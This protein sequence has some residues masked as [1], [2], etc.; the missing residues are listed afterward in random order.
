MKSK[1]FYVLG[2]VGFIAFI[3]GG[4]LLQRGSDEAGSI[5]QQARLFE[6]V[7]AYIADYYVDPIDEREIYDMAID[8]LL[9]ELDDPYTVFLRPA[10]F[11]RLSISTT[12]N[13]GG[14]GIRIEVSDGWI[15][16]VTPL[17]DT[18]AERAGVQAGDRIVE[19]E[20]ESTR[21]WPIDRA[22]SV[23]RGP[24]GE[25]AN[26]TIVRPGVPEPI[27]FSIKRERIHVRAV[28]FGTVFPGGIGYVQFATIS[29]SSARE[30]GEEVAR[31]QQE[32]ATSLILDLRNNPGGLL[33]EGVAVSDLFLDRGDV[34][35]ETRGRAPGASEVFRASR[36]QQWTDMPLIALVNGASASAAEIIAGALQDHDRALIL[37]TPS[38]GKGLVQ[39]VY[40]LGPGRRALKITTGR[41][42]TPTGRV[43]ER[44]QPPRPTLVAGAAADDE[45]PIASALV[46]PDSAPRFYTDAGRVVY[47]GG[48]I[49]PDRTVELTS[50]S[51]GEEEFARQLGRR[52]PDYRSVLT[53]YA[54]DIKGEGNITAL[55]FAV[56]PAMRAELVRR[57][58]E[59][60]IDLED[61]VWRGASELL[62]RVL[63][64][65]IARYVFGRQAEVQRQLTRDA[66][67]QEALSLLR[68]AGSPSELFQLAS[69][70]QEDSSR[71]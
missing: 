59:R 17:P 42:Y 12:G 67:V 60:G 20:G 6:N 51:D 53:S 63:G 22:V 24:A 62:N 4:W 54:L 23:L 50:L 35:V 61:D 39:T 71:N 65:E 41:W 1:N 52:I 18:P 64:Y 11:E 48:G 8:G 66:Q 57:L 31:L 16:V 30:L 33:N 46:P 3:S 32:G 44:P 34:V 2:L 10:D 5:Y 45:D 26:I 55:D 40:E 43:L 19:V 68:L 38:F 69:R 36:D 15:T 29:E 37:G 28:Q 49:Y 9:R 14:L 47:G 27:P 56:T 70:A 25:P 13:Y 7:V 58:E 21:E